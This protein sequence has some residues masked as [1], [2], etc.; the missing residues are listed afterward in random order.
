MS[1]L[2][3]AFCRHQICIEDEIQVLDR[4]VVPIIKLTDRRTNVRV[5]MSFNMNGGPQSTQ[6]ILVRI[7][8]S[9]RI[10]F[11]LTTEATVRN[12]ILLF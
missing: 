5:D 3:D 11:R 6:L 12:R 9:S 1:D 2:R 7:Y 10:H 8:D 4:A